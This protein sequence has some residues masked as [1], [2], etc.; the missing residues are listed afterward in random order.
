M[1]KFSDIEKKYIKELYD[2]ARPGEC[3]IPANLFYWKFLENFATYYTDSHKFVFLRDAENK[4]PKDLI[5][6]TDKILMA[7]SLLDYLEKEGLIFCIRVEE[8]KDEKVPS[9]LGLSENTN[10]VD[11][12][13][14]AIGV[15]IPSDMEEILIKS[16]KSRVIVNETLVN[17]V[18]NGFKTIEELQLDEARIQSKTAIE[19]LDEARTQSKTAI[20]SLNEARTQS[21]KAIESLEEAKKQTRWSIGAVVVAVITMFVTIGFQVYCTQSVLVEDVKPSV[22][23][24][25]K[26]EV[27]PKPA[28]GQKDV[29]IV[30]KPKKDGAKTTSDN[31]VKNKGKKSQQ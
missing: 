5:L 2:K 3:Y 14:I 21:E 9:Y 20:E 22:I 10:L 11:E 6:N 12:D 27:L 15:S 19:S 18:D 31:G 7:L 24:T 30:E 4:D 23:Q 17:Y 16:M 13:A 25:V 1:R 28:V 26:K 8:E 29:P